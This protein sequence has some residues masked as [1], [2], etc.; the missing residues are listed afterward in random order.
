MGG[1][2][3]KICGGGT[4]KPPLA[5]N[6]VSS[7][8][9]AY[10]GEYT[11]EKE[12]FGIPAPV[13]E[14][15]EKKKRS[16]SSGAATSDDDDDDDATTDSDE[17]TRCASDD[18]GLGTSSDV[19]SSI[20][21]GSP[22]LA[23]A[24]WKSA[25]PEGGTPTAE[26]DEEGLT[27]SEKRD[28]AELKELTELIQ[29][30]KEPGALVRVP[31]RKVIPDSSNRAGTC[32]SVEHVH[33][34]AHS[35]ATQGF[36]P[37][38]DNQGHDI[39]V[40]VRERVDSDLGAKAVRAWRA[41]LAEEPGFPPASYYEAGSFKGPELFTSLGNGHF[42]QALNLF[43]CESSSIHD[44]NRRY[45]I[46]EDRKLK[47]A[48]DIGVP[49]LVLRGGMS[50]KERETVSRLLNSKREYRWIEK[51]DG[52]VDVSGAIEDTGNASQFERLSKELDAEEL[53]CLIREKL[54]LK[55][56]HRVGR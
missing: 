4:E 16:P 17:A 3:S 2:A 31:P 20:D 48:V 25:E 6:T 36:V 38:K 43:A 8:A 50:P 44:P 22:G 13:F 53:N 21:P 47:E 33:Y 26:P 54:K 39:P 46:R 19:A 27:D 9:A 49:A 32:L 30:W 40:L 18:D 42:N 5:S 10:L 34:L 55:D 1:L 45:A 24:A 14:V 29:K 15:G 41:K 12:T 56:S 35:F 7:Y 52:S 23:V 11:D 51:P 28:R 37:R